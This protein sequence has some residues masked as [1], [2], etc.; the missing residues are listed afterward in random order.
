[1]LSIRLLCQNSIYAQNVLRACLALAALTVAYAQDRLVNLHVVALD[2][3]DRP[4]RDL[5]TDDFQ[6]KEQGRNS[7][8]AVFRKSGFRAGA[9]EPALGPH[10]F[11]NRRGSFGDGDSLGFAASYG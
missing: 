7:R 2:S 4:V 10:E 9:A 6:I 1:M 3:H 8:I 5:T 11:S